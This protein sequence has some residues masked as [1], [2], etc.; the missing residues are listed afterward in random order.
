M[1]GMTDGG[2]DGWRE[3]RMAGIYLPVV[4]AQAGIQQHKGDALGYGKYWDTR[5]SILHSVAPL[6]LLH[7]DAQEETVTCPSGEPV[8]EAFRQLVVVF[9][10]RL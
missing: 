9:E 2:N 1:A 5:S 4:P 10:P 3:R 8:L 6:G 7:L